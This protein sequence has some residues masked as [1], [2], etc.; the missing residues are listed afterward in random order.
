MT[1]PT[2]GVSFELLLQALGATVATAVVAPVGTQLVPIG[3]VVLLEDVD[4]GAPGSSGDLG[5]LVGVSAPQAQAWL[6]RLASVDVGAAA[7]GGGHQ[8]LVD[9]SARCGSD[10]P[11]SL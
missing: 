9:G 10:G 5:V 2:G 3:S 11:G 7:A 6:D 8:A 1:T 4:L